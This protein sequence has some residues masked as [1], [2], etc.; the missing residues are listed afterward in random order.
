VPFTIRSATTRIALLAIVIGAQLP[1]GLAT[2]VAETATPDHLVVSEIVTG[3]AS[4][5]DEL[6]ELYNPTAVSLPLEG[7][8]VIYVSASGATVTRRASWDVGAPMVPAGGHVLVANEAGLFASI[9]DATYASGMAATGGSVAIRILGST[10]AVDAV[11][12]GAAASGWMEGTPAVA[13]AAGA[14]IERLPGAAAGSWQDTGINAADFVERGVPHPQNLGSVPV[15]PGEPA[16]QTP[17]PTAGSPTPVPSPDPEPSPAAPGATPISVARGLAD[18]SDVTIEGHAL[19]GSDFHDGGGFVADATGGIAILVTD[20][21][22]ARR[23]LLRLSGELDDRFAQRTLRV[24]GATIAVLGSGADP[25]APAVATGAVGEAAEGTLVHTSGSIV[26]SGSPLTTGV[27]FDLDDG[28]GP[29]RLVIPSASGIDTSTWASGTTV[30]LIGVVGQ[31][32]SGGSGTS[33]YRVIPRD[34]ADVIA[35]SQPS[36]IPTPRPSGLT[37]VPVPSEPP[38]SGEVVSIAT[39]RAAP[40]NARLVVR[41]V[42]TLPPGVV[43]EDTAVIQDE[44][45]A[46]VLRVGD[47]SGTLRSG[48][49]V[50]VTGT[51]STKSGMETLRVTEPVRS[52]GSSRLPAAPTLRT[53]DVGEGQEA[54]L[55]VVRGEIVAS[56]RRASSGSVS[57]DLDDGSGPLKVA[58]GSSLAADSTRLQ[59]GTWVE[60]LAVVG[61]QTT[62]AKPREGYR[63]WPASLS[64]VVAVASAG[65]GGADE[66]DHPDGAVDPPNADLADLDE[67]DLSSLRVGATL[68]VGPWPELGIGG[69][70]WDGSRL[71]AIDDR[72]ADIVASALGGRLPP[73][74]VELGGLAASGA[75][76]VSGA[77]LV[78]LSLD[79]ADVIAGNGLV[80]APHTRLTGSPSWVSMIGLLGSQRDLPVL[81]VRGGVVRLDARCE[82]GLLPKRGL[83]SVT[84]IALSDPPRIVLPCGGARAVPLLA[85]FAA[86]T[87]SVPNGRASQNSVAS[88]ERHT[89]G[90]LLAA[91]LLTVA[92]TGLGG[93]ALWRRLRPGATDPE[94]A[95]ADREPVGDPEA[96]AGP[97]RLT[98]VG[99]PRERGP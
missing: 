12:W 62:G 4:A 50:E 85:L 37:G 98:L 43:D 25:D 14:S 39:A 60:A 71:V 17:E 40:K 52:L 99:V 82:A 94:A 58:L 56:A 83:V 42:V 21:A 81:R 80:A 5:S 96:E 70:L 44:T 2:V 69:L 89:D 48:Q 27:A 15:P 26:G 53:G 75:E 91:G 10:T 13:P 73:V 59:A 86:F 72:S 38:A 65:G 33:G 32:D 31:R 92:A 77:P 64:A 57:F 1:L 45:G 47:E 29:T 78:S 74:G 16:A 55:V 67:A 68:V 6:I 19:T 18:G 8:E 3:G 28:S 61:Q 30:D 35:V 79:P 93:I 76:P 49:R 23:A 22:F 88:P 54:R 66:N 9:A 24:S 97:P 51:R 87:P 46:I 7:L 34:P 95:I 11:G 84:G 63:L 90:R 36:P 20:G 41:G